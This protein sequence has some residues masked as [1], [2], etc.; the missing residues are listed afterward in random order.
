MGEMDGLVC[1]LDFFAVRG[2]RSCWRCEEFGEGV[3]VR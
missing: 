1:L 2:D 3:R